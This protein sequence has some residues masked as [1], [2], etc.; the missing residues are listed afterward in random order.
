MSI[1][2]SRMA[3]IGVGVLLVTPVLYLSVQMATIVNRSYR[4]E[5]AVEYDMSDSIILD[6]YAGFSQVSVSEDGTIG[7]LV[8]DGERVSTGNA[9]AEIYTSATQ[10]I[11]RQQLNDLDAR[12]TLLK[13][14]QN[15]SSSDVS[16]VQRQMQNA[17][18]D[19]LDVLDSGKYSDFSGESN[20]YLL[21]ANQMQIITGQSTGFEE[22]ISQLEA[23]KS[24]VEAQLG[25]P[26]TI[27]AP[28]GGYFVSAQTTKLLTLSP[29]EL[30]AMSAADLQTALQSGQGVA[31]VDGAGKIVTSYTWQFYTV[32]SQEES[33]KFKPDAKVEISFPGQA[34]KKLPAVVESVE[35][36]EATGLAKVTLR[37]EYVN[38]EVLALTIAQAQIDF[39]SYAGVRI[40]ADALHIVDGVKG[41][42]VKYGN[43]VRF[44]KIT[45]LYQD[46]EYILVP[47]DGKVGTD[48]EV[49]LFDEVIVQGLNLKDG[50][51]I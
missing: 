50:A 8:D 21:S 46:D 36:D 39:E 22:T 37:C 40:S 42:Y 10:A 5:T 49:R 28:V 25:Q 24:A 1:S 34:E 44:R 4:T 51:L 15:T 48:N 19:V 3:A 35:L 43:L 30:Q 32:C 23:E 9:V 27:T 47:E 11:S 20:D 29:E 14:S 12:I 16:M 38:T 17:F 41:V 2:K 33:E 6:G 13:K 18:Y 7:Y 45:I 31:P 26:T